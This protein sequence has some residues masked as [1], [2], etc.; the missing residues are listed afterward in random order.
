LAD[1]DSSDHDLVAAHQAGNSQALG[2]LLDRHL[3][4][5]WNLAYQLALNPHAADDL[6]Q[7]ACL[8]AIRGL[9][10]FRGNSAFRTWLFRIV[11]NASRDSFAASSSKR[12]ESGG[13]DFDPPA[14]RHERPEQV[15]MQVEL[16]EEMTRALQALPDHLRAAVVLTTLQGL[17]PDEAADVE[18]C[19]TSTIYWRIHEARKALRKHLEPWTT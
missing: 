13:E 12:T 2:W 9:P 16:E 11:I 19:T 10:N 7:E 1:A 18:G 6:T 17:T 8:R 15:A 14:R 3:K 5:A 4:A